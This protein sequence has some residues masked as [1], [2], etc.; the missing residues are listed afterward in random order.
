[1]RR[2]WLLGL[3]ALALALAACGGDD[4]GGGG[5]GSAE[6]QYKLT[7]IQG[8]KGD[9]FYVTM[10]CGAQEAARAAGATLDVAAPDEFDA[11]LQTPVVN[12]VV[13]KKPDAILVAPTD[14]QAMIPPLTQAKQAGIKLV[15]VDTTTENGAELAES[16]IASDNEEGGREAA[17]TLAELTGGKGSVLVINVKPGI[18]TTDARAKGFEDEIKK[19]PGLKYIGQEYSNDKPEIAAS[20]A[21]AALAAHPD[22]VGIFGT[23]LFSA[24]GAATGLRSAGATKKVKIVGFDA[25]PKQVEDLEQGIVQ[26]LIAQKPADIGRAGVEQAIAALKGESVQKKIGTGF[27]V[28]TKEN[29]NSPD[30]EPFLYKSSC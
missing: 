21:T 27:V 24:E 7:L 3:A 16:E 13:A 6:K 12:A 29:M 9:Q 8:V 25:G 15:F 4:D 26:A 11:S 23:N 30:V 19:T 14:T 17:R 1:M 18:S 28:V 5:A 10:Q 20:K 22:L 2:R